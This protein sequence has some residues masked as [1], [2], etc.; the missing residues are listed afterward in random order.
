MDR[1]GP[2]DAMF[3]ELEKSGPPVAVGAVSEIDGEAPD[4]DAVRDFVAGRISGMPRFRQRV[5][6]S[7]TKIRSMKW[8]EVEPDLTHHVR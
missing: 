3:L 4:V 5:E 2:V 8:V 1:L 7:R 6:E